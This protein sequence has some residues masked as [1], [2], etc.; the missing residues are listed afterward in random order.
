MSAAETRRILAVY[1]SAD[2][3]Q[4][5]AGMDWYRTAQFHAR[6]IANDN[7]IS[8]E[9]AAGIIAALSPQVS[10]GFNLEWSREVA[11]GSV[12]NR[13]LN[14]N[15]GKAIA[16][17]SNGRDPL[18]ILG[19]PKVRAF[20]ACIISAGIT[21]EVCIDRHAYDIATGRRGSAQNGLTLKRSR[22]AQDAYR[23]AA[24]RLQVTG[25]ATLS[26]AQLQAITWVTW[27]ARYWAT[28]AFDPRTLDRA[29]LG[30]F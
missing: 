9:C 23:R 10:W 11:A 21:D 28:G 3:E 8:M 6:T 13:G 17:L 2:A 27:R 7:G 30:A 25:E 18:D 26:A 15:M 12:I 4:I 22:A 14:T 16:I 24:H 19:G 20:Y 29:P 1:R 5:A